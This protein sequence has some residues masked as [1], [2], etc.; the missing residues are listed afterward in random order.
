LG[1]SQVAAS[2]D[3]P[4][5]YGSLYQ[6]GRN[7]DGHEVINWTSSSSSDGLEQD[8][9][10]ILKR[11]NLGA[12]INLADI[13]LSSE[14][15]TY[16]QESQDWC[17]VLAGGDDYQLCFTVAQN[18]IKQ[19]ERLSQDL[20]VKLTPIGTITQELGLERLGGFEKKCTSYKHF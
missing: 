10:H 16:I 18:K 1:A 17:L 8:L 19:V 5:S 3:D 15:Q 4:A 14:V 13:P 7:S 20:N 6:W 9:G 2:I 11:S 12:R